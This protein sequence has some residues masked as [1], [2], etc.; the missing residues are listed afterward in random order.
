MLAGVLLVAGCSGAAPGPAAD[1]APPVSSAAAPASP[2]PAIATTDTTGAPLPAAVLATARV[3][4][5]AL[6]SGDPTPV[7][8]RYTPAPGAASWTVVADRLSDPANQA[9][10]ASALRNP[11]E[12]R[13]E[14]AYLFSDGDHGFGLA[15]DGR[16]AFV[17]VGQRAPGTSTG[18]PE[19][20]GQ[21]FWAGLSYGHGRSLDVDPS[22][23]GLMTFRTYETCPSQRPGVPCEPDGPQ[24]VGRVDLRIYD[25][26]GGP[27]VAEV[28]ASNDEPEFPVGDLLPVEEPAPGVVLL[29]SGDRT[30]VF[31]TD[32]ATHDGCGA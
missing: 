6:S 11:P 31:C 7:R 10:L 14:I 29:G 1:P 3:L 8:D 22:G 19:P 24:Q 26:G 17:G 21:P 18:V 13:P 25:V 32:G 2:E 5:D 9:K 30:L 12:P 15:A 16:L 27:W 4:D 23:T 20:T 28:V